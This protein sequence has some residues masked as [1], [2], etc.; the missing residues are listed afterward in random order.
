VALYSLARDEDLDRAERARLDAERSRLEA[1]SAR[2]D[3][4]KARREAL[5]VFLG[6][7]FV[8]PDLVDLRDVEVKRNG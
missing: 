4:D 5:R 1:D 7:D 3:A 8:D 6:P 2:L